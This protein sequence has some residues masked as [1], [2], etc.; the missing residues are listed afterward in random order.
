MLKALEAVGRALLA[1][2]AALAVTVVAAA[3]GIMV[4]GIILILVP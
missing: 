2:L 4:L 3:L 1:L